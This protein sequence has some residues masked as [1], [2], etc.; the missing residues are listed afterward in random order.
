MSPEF[1]SALTIAV[2][3]VAQQRV[4][5]E[6]CVHADLMRASRGN[7]HFHQRREWTQELHR[8]E[9]AHRVLTGRRHAHMPLTMLAVCRVPP[10]GTGLCPR[11]A[12]CRPPRPLM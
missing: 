8:L 2:F 3:V 1:G 9:Y 4:A 10:G 6:R 12:P 11:A 7:V 5:G